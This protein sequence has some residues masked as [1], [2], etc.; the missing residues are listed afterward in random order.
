MSA[1]EGIE[2]L[3]IDA[4]R[5]SER[6]PAAA[7]QTGRHA[8]RNWRVWCINLPLSDCKITKK[9]VKNDSAK[10]E[11]RSPRVQLFN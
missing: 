11:N 2:A 7:K 3:L 9:D 8:H 10:P 5:P 4:V 1:S 6:V